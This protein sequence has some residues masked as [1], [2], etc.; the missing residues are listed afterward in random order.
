[1]MTT[2]T[3]KTT[4]MMRK[5]RSGNKIIEVICNEKSDINEGDRENVMKFGRAVEMLSD[6]SSSTGN[7]ETTELG[8]TD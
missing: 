7:R 6:C 4:K 8:E 1:M 5:S 3:K 2:M